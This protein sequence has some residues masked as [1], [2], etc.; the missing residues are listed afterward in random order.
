MNYTPPTYC[1]DGTPL[2]SYCTEV[3][4]D[5]APSISP[6]ILCVIEAQVI[7]TAYTRI[8]KKVRRQRT[9]KNR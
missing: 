6:E 7:R 5:T 1:S 3:P 4:P 2:C 9:Q 8:E